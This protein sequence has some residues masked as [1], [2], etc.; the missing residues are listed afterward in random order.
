MVTDLLNLLILVIKYNK[1]EKKKT[2]IVIYQL[3]N[4]DHFNIRT[5]TSLGIGYIMFCL[6]NSLKE[7]IL[8]NEVVDS[9]LGKAPTKMITYYTFLLERNTFL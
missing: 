5:F 6:S 3:L 4:S 7:N 2:K 9:T 1:N 8:R